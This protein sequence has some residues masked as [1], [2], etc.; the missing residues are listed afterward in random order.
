MVTETVVDVV[1]VGSGAGGGTLARALAGSDVSVLVVERGGWLPQEKQNWDPTEVWRKQ[2]Y[3]E[4]ETWFN[5][6]GED[7]QPFM[8]YLVGGNTKFWGAVLYRLREEDFTE[9]AHV[10]GVSPAWP[11]D[12]QAMAPYYDRAEEI[13][14][15]HGEVGSDPTDPDRKP[16]PFPAVPHEPPIQAV[17]DQLRD[18]GVTPSYL[19]L[20]LINPGEA[21]GC[22]LCNTCNSFPC[23]VRGKAD[24]DTVAMTPA[25]EADNITLWTH[26][27]VESV[28]TDGSGRR[29]TG[30]VVRR[31]GELVTVRADVVV[32]SAGAVNSA[33][34][35]LRSAT[36]EHPEGL[37]NSSGLVGRR[38]MAHHATMMEAFHPF[39]VNETVF[40]KTV[41]INDFYRPTKGRSYPLGNIQSQGRAHAP[42][43]KAAAPYAPLK[44]ADAFVRRG[45]DWLAMTE[46]LPDPA[47]RVTVTREGRIRLDYQGN[48]MGPHTELVRESVRLFKRLGYWKVITHMFKN[49]NTTH[50]CGTA[51]FGD[52]PRTSV[53]DPFCRTHDLDNLYVVDASFFPSSAAVNPG[54][55]VIAQSLRVAEHLQ[56][57]FGWGRPAGGASAVPT[58]TPQGDLT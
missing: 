12:Y 13:Y 32:L 37:G 19:P 53:L 44:L 45:V 17:V 2:R 10:D 39:R 4:S 40:Q 57:R 16:F 41:G 25:L 22:I 11:I 5:R 49:E 46:D 42:I 15:V 48:S 14:Q 6:R 18:E 43:V 24:A 52:D 26:S 47:N 29:A 50:Q 7:F 27:R 1:V 31:D 9:V 28:L 35:L 38:F 36:T 21:G 20:G 34:L 33:A 51:V 56:D 8:H 30:V 3:R 54:L 55:T 58:D 23:L